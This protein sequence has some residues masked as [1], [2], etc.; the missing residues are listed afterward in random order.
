M[1]SLGPGSDSFNQHNTRAP[2][3]CGCATEDF[4][5]GAANAC[6]CL[7]GVWQPYRDVIVTSGYVGMPAY[8]EAELQV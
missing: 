2:F 3:S 8:L 6:G 5:T 7:V 1:D 4:T